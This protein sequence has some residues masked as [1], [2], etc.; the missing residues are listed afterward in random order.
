MI[1]PSHQLKNIIAALFSS[2]RNETKQFQYRDTLISW[3][4]IM[5]M[6]EREKNRALNN[7]IRR[8]PNLLSSYFHRDQCFRLNV[9]A[10][11][12]MQQDHVLAELK[13]FMA[14]RPND[15]SLSLTVQYLECCNKMFE[16]GL[17]T[18]D[19]NKVD[20]LHVLESIEYGFY[21]LMGWCDDALS[22]DIDIATSEQRSF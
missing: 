1:C 13:E 14:S 21:F 6:Y 20:D 22:R 5:D 17:L 11:K 3:Y 8:V 19:K 15:T 9:K 16:Q 12:V 10:S 2:R 7:Q 4:P 18:H